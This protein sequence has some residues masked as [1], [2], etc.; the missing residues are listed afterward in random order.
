VCKISLSE[1]E[2]IKDTNGGL[3][4]LECYNKT[5]P[6]CYKC[7][8][9]FSPSELYQKIDDTI[10]L[11]NKCF[12]CSGP[13]KKPMSGEFYAMENDKYVCVECYDKYGADYNQEQPSASTQSSSVQRTPF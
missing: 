9:L 8:Q 11:H 2:F 10:F 13:C 12:L 3:L 7:N 6:K 4:C 5:A 1:K